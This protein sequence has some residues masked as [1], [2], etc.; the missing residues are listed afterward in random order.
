M[1]DKSSLTLGLVLKFPMMIEK[2][3]TETYSMQIFKKNDG[4]T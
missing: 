4:K 1:R 3:I 2:K